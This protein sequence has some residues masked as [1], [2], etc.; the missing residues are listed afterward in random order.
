MVSIDHYLDEFKSDCDLKIKSGE[1]LLVSLLDC[2]V[3][4]AN[5]L[6]LTTICNRVSLI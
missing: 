6:M 5:R 3:Y 1:L 4:D 2:I